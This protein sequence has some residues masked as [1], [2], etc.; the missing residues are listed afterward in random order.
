MARNVK[1]VKFIVDHG[2]PH[3]KAEGLRYAQRDDNTPIIEYLQTIS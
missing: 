2:C 1:I 3:D